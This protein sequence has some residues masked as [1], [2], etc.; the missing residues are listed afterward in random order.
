MRIALTKEQQE[1]FDNNFNKD[2]YEQAKQVIQVAISKAKTFMD[3][4][5]SLNS[6]ERDNGFDD[7]YSII[8]CE[9]ELDRSHMA[10]TADYV[11]VY[12]CI[13]W[14]D[15]TESAHIGAVSLYTS[16]TP[17]GQVECLCSFH[18]DTCEIIRWIYN[19]VRG[20]LMKAADTI[21]NNNEKKRNR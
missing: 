6:Y 5:N 14:D 17:D 1:L 8:Y 7:D 2:A 9:V 3:L 20:R 11:G 15:E 4:W 16:D 13:C 18:P 12:F 19:K 21:N 10:T